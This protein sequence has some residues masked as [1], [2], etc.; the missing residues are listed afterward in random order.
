MID[1]YMRYLWDNGKIRNPDIMIKVDGKVFPAHTLLLK[2]HSNYFETIIKSTPCA[3]FY[4]IPADT[5]IKA[6]IFSILI[7]FIYTSDLEISDVLTLERVLSASEAIGME[8]T[9]YLCNWLM[10]LNE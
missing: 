1:D 10:Q 3:R 8:E 6:D 7:R 4:E 2:V 5:N 9:K